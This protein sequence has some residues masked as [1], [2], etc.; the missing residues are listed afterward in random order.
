VNE[1]KAE[2]T[3]I[4]YF[5]RADTPSRNSP[6]GSLMR[7]IM[8]ESPELRFEQARQLANLLTCSSCS[9]TGSFVRKH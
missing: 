5:D 1:A 4:D 3:A 2:L 6:V 7:R 9:T 8:A